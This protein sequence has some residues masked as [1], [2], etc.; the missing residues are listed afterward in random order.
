METV[1]A[2]LRIAARIAGASAALVAVPGNEAP[3]A[4]WGV[5]AAAAGALLRAVRR[6]WPSGA[7]SFRCY[8]LTLADGSAA[9]LVLIAP[10]TDGDEAALTALAVEIGVACGPADRVADGGTAIERLTESLEQ[11]G[12]ATAILSSPA[13]LDSA[14]HVLHVNAGFTQLYGFAAAEIVGKGADCMWGPLSDRDRMRWLTSRI[15]ERGAGRA[16]VI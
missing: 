15:T 7:W 13:D 9:D 12:E 5:D 1:T 10:A 16:V 14:P 4:A 3:V 6:A 2:L 11:L 8:P